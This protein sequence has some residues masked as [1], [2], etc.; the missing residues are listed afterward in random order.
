MSVIDDFLQ[1]VPEPQKTELLRVRTII[2]DAAPDA[3]EVISYGMPA[4]K[5]NGKYLIGFSPFAH[6]MSL[7]PG[8]APVAGLAEKL[9]GYT[10]SKGTIQ[11]T[12]EHPL[13]KDLIREIV[14]ACVARNN[15]D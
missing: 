1:N 8:A 11:F 12:L 10:L 13:P 3:E 6:H 14:A 9:S 2:C 15:A 5:Y 4:Y 7:F